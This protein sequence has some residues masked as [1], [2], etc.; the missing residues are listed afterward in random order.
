MEVTVLKAKNQLSELMR[1]AERGE[2]III[3]RGLNGKAF[4]LALEEPVEKPRRLEPH[5]GWKKAIA[6]RDED[7]F[8]SNGRKEV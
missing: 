4:R 6:Y 8:E 2:E 5:R 7:L 3:R 1:R